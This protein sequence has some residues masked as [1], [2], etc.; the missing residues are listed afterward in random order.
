V[1]G[2]TGPGCLAS[3]LTL[4][5]PVILLLVAMAGFTGMVMAARGLPAAGTTLV[6]GAVLLLTAAGSAM[7]NSVLDFSLDCRMSRLSARVRAL[8]RLGR[9]RTVLLAVALIA[10]GILLAVVQL[11]LLV[12]LVT[13]AAVI[14]YLYPY[15]L[16]LKRSSPF[17]AIPG[18]IPGALPVLIGY[19]AVSPTI[20][21]DGL[22]LFLLVL[23]WQPPHFWTLAL[24]FQEDYRAAGLPVLPAAKGEH[25][26][27]TFIL[28]YATSLIPLSLLLWFFSYCSAGFAVAALLAG[29]IFLA[30]LIRFLFF[31]PHFLHAFR[32]TNG[33]LTVIL[34]LIVADICL[35]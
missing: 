6:C 8:E 14:G 19:G 12:T 31:K 11:N 30:S 24:R 28:L 18:A 9:T 25:Y 33:Y 21:P 16:R 22:I 15:T 23:L 7:I 29:G 5:R 27:K 10:S 13:L 26:T 3:V 20:E 34:L 35:Q 17:G 32:A 2:E 1:T 4:T